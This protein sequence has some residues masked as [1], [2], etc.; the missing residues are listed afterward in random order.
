MKI[1]VKD[2]EKLKTLIWLRGETVSGF[3][4]EINSSAGYVSRIIAG[5]M[6]PQP[7]LAK[8]IVDGLSTEK[9]VFSI[10]DIFKITE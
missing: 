5:E 9:K 7:P 10:D 2:P 3:A 1:T 6:H 8:R 4:K